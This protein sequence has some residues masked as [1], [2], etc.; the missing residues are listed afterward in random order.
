[1]VLL[2]W[3]SGER[4]VTHGP[5][6]GDPRPPTCAMAQQEE[7]AAADQKACLGA[8]LQDPPMSQNRGWNGGITCLC[9]GGHFNVGLVLLSS[10]CIWLEGIFLLIVRGIKNPAL[11]EGALWNA[12]RVTAKHKAAVKY[13]VGLY[14]IH[15]SFYSGE[16]FLENYGQIRLLLKGTWRGR[17][18]TLFLMPSWSICP[19][20]P[21][22]YTG[23]SLDYLLA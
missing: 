5:Q 17:E 14:L 12:Y 7:L 4:Q 23:L 3:L 19:I 21:N 22:I 9:K 20:Y 1:M 13:F 6:L 16:V 2:T 11:L 18:V 10:L 15:E 8:L